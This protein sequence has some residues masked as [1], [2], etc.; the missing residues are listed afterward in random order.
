MLVCSGQPTGYLATEADYTSY[1][2]RWQ[3]RWN[4]LE[5]TAGNSGVLLRA[6]SADVEQGKVW[7]KSL[8]VQ[9][10]GGSAGDLWIIDGF[11][12]QVAPERTEGRRTRAAQDNER[13]VGLWNDGVVVLDGGDLSIWVN[14]TL[15]NRASGVDQTP[16]KI[17]L[18]SEG[19][20]V[21]FRQLL[22]MPLD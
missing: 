8:E 17:A 7:P 6:S 19:A 21:H 2:L 13:E 4:P 15:V 12:A 9:L 5:R 18:Q 16:G 10:E 14:G 3:W 20:E 1:V 22:I 11:P